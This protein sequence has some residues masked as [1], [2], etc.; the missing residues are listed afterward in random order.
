LFKDFGGAYSSGSVQDFHLIPFSFLSR[1]HEKET[2]KPEA[3][4]LQ[5]LLIQAKHP[6]KYFSA[7]IT[8]ISQQNVK[9]I[10][11]LFLVV[12]KVDFLATNCPAGAKN[13]V[14]WGLVKR[15]LSAICSKLQLRVTS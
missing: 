8:L 6:K 1:G 2:P 4:I 10:I 15:D 13:A 5:K 12:E 14:I 7:Q 11:L 3:K 9:T